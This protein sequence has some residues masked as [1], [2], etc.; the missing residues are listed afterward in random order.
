MSKTETKIDVQEMGDEEQKEAEEIAE[1]S[2]G[3]T[4]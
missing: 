4:E 3:G 2:G 1:P